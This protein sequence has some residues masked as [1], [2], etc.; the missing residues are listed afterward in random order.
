M[1]RPRCVLV[2]ACFSAGLIRAQAIETPEGF[3][4]SLTPIMERIQRERGY[5]F[6]YEHKGNLSVEQWR[7]RGR[8]AVE[9]SLSYEPKM[10]PLD[11]QV[12]RTEKRDGYEFRLIS[13]AGSAQYRIPAFLLVPESGKPPYPAV[14]AFHDHGAY[15]YFGKEKIVEVD[16]EHAS[17]AAYKQTYYGGRSYASE[18]AR[19]GYVVIVIDA[20]YWGDRRLQYRDPPA[21]WLKITAGLDPASPKYVDT[22][23]NYLDER[24]LVQTQ[25]DGEI[26]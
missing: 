7:K 9:R 21:A 20:F 3:L 8:A 1:K 6:D 12:H 10:V 2:I 22:V 5:A 4:G 23:N 11:I 25:G 14:V 15:F 13:F 18:L 17:L 19:R 26:G 24:A 16:N